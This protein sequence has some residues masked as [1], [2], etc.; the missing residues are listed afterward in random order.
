M[1][2]LPDITVYVES[3]ERRIVGHKLEK[4]RLKSRDKRCLVNSTQYAI[5]R[6][7][8][9]PIFRRRAVNLEDIEQA[10]IEPALA[11]LH[12]SGRSLVDV[13]SA[14]PSMA[15]AIAAI[16]GGEPPTRIV[17]KKIFNRKIRSLIETVVR[18]SNG[19]PPVTFPRTDWPG[20]LS[21]RNPGILRASLR[22]PRRWPPS[23]YRLRGTAATLTRTG[24]YI[25]DCLV[26]V[27]CFRSCRC[28]CPSSRHPPWPGH[29]PPY[30]VRRVRDDQIDLPENSGNSYALTEAE[31][32]QL[33]PEVIPSKKIA[34][35]A[36]IATVVP[37]TPAPAR[38]ERKSA[39]S[40]PSLW[41]RIKQMFSGEA[42]EKS[43]SR[44][45]SG[46]QRNR[47]RNDNRRRGGQR[48]RGRNDGQ[49]QSNARSNDNRN[50][51]RN[52]KSAK[53]RHKKPAEN[54]KEN[55]KF[56]CSCN[57]IFDNFICC[58]GSHKTANLTV[59]L[60]SSY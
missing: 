28:S 52:K 1:P 39:K 30:Q 41:E 24:L 7:L 8:R 53:K 6:S 16:R 26:P 25:A 55:T 42:E 12:R 58:K 48:S 60:K 38:K 18:P 5:E 11:E 35:A 54:T 31:H 34:E 37:P 23:A 47:G 40:G 51:N 36:A 43:S 44:Q 3:L 20:P 27:P 15:A 57:L 22:V 56:F 49:R 2:E 46:Q 4:I 50:E 21:N 10:L 45:R 29:R 9:R 14:P 59:N 32:E 19:V 17:R 33:I 13:I